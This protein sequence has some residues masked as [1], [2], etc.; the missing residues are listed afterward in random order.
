MVDE[1]IYRQSIKNA[2]ILSSIRRVILNSS[3]KIIEDIK[4]KVPYYSCNRGI[5]YMNVSKGM[6]YLAFLKGYLMDVNEINLKANGRKI[7]KSIRFSEFSLKDE[8]L[9]NQLIHEALIL[10]EF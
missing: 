3:F 8:A 9:V 1:Y 7:V 6:V 4:Y 10:D 5:C 2:E